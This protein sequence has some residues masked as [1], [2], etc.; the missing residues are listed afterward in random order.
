MRRKR[1]GEGAG[2]CEGRPLTAPRAQTTFLFNGP[3]LGFSIPELFVEFELHSPVQNMRGVSAAGVPV[4]G[5]GHNGRMAWG[6]TSGLSDEDDL[7]AEQLTGPETYTFRGPQRQMGC[8]DERFDYRSPHGPARPLGDGSRRAAWPAPV[9]AHLPHRSRPCPGAGQGRGL[10]APVRDLGPRAGD[11]RRAVGAQRR[12][13]GAPADRALGVTW[14]EN[15]IAADDRGNIGDRH[16]GLHPLR[17]RNSDKRLPYP[18]TGEAEWRGL[19]SPRKTPQVINPRQGYVISGKRA[20]GGLDR[21]RRS[22]A[23]ALTGRSTAP[24]CCGGWCHGSPPSPPT[25]PRRRSTAAA[26][27]PPSSAPFRQLRRARR[28]R[29]GKSRELLP[30][31]T[32][33]TAATP[34]STRRGVDPG[35]AVWEE[36]RIRPSRSPSAHSRK[37]GLG[38]ASLRA[39]RHLAQVR[40]LQRRGVCAAHPRPRG[41]RPAAAPTTRWRPAS[42]PQ[43]GHWREPRRMYDTARG[44]RPHRTCRSST[45]APGSS[46][47][48]RGRRGAAPAHQV[49]GHGLGRDASLSFVARHDSAQADAA[50]ACWRTSRPSGPGRN[51]FRPVPGEVAVVIH[52]RSAMLAF[53]APWLPLA[54]LAAAPAG[55]R[56]F[57]GWFARRRSTCSP[58]R[59]SRAR[60]GRG[61][62]RGAAGSPRHEYSHLVLGPPT[63]PCRRR[64]RRPPSGA[65]CAPPGCARAP[66][67][68]W[69]P[70]APPA[71]RDRAPAARGRAGRVPAGRPRRP[72]ARGHAVRAA[73][74]ERGP[75]A[76]GARR[77]DNVRD[78]RGWSN[79]PSGARRPPSSALVRLPGLAQ[80]RLSRRG[81]SSTCSSAATTRGSNCVPAPR[82]SSAR[83]GSRHRR[84]V[85]AVGGHRV[86]GVAGEDDARAQRDVLAPQPVGVAQ[87]VPALV[88]VAHQRQHV[89]EELDGERMRS[90]T[91]VWRSIS[92]LRA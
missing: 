7:Y 89:A 35:V 9:R 47:S 80:R 72:P 52:P 79:R 81:G 41:L 11:A 65:T 4:V 92:P 14:N 67:P 46:R 78:R 74:V 12:A 86:V 8:R 49:P 13:E 56:Y 18:G 64:S 27:R 32:S 17:P 26:V 10:R 87:A 39:A 63:P 43:P 24:A 21:R 51:A 59:R 6:F 25:R 36:S 88:L 76:R 29:R 58:P 84:A 53:A 45:A 82:S 34:A 91:S 42:A 75:H 71:C 1:S 15:V 60:S 30:T 70:G 19:L 37:G 69:R 40:H 90:P 73:G 33:G 61:L 20:L 77:R 54:R 55:R 2:A 57:A 50:R 62:A 38:G 5:I 44:P 83:A 28:D 16:P 68:S 31:L 3:Q 85:G 22:G 23:R 48:H 66:P